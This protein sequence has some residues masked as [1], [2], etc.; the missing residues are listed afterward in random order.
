AASLAK[1]YSLMNLSTAPIDTGSERAFKKHAPSHKP[2]RRQTRL[3]ISRMLL[4]VRESAAASRNRPSAVKASH[5]GMR[6]AS[7]HPVFAHG[8]SGQ[9]MQRLACARTV[10]SS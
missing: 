7:G 5:S 2:S 3:Q 8:G 10:S 6:F 4:V 9:L 1:A